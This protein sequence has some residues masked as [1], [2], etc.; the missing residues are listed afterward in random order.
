[1]QNLC[2]SGKTLCLFP[3]TLLISDNLLIFFKNT[4]DIT[5][6]AHKMMGSEN[7]YCLRAWSETSANFYGLSVIG[8]RTNGF[9]GEHGKSND[10]SNDLGRMY[11]KWNDSAKNCRKVYGKSNYGKSIGGTEED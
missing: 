4:E 10:R 8:V 7:G 11:G 5:I 1:M 6:L 2:K 9:D 3:K